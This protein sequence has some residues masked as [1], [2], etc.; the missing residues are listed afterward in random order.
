MATLASGVMQGDLPYALMGLGAAIAL[1]VECSGAV[2]L[3]FAIGL[4]LPITTSAPLILGGLLRSALERRERG[5]T[6]RATL[7]A[8]GL[9][10]GDALMGIGIAGLVVSGLAERL[11]LRTVG[12]AGSPLEIV[13]TVAPFAMLALALA[14]WARPTAG[15]PAA[16]D[17]H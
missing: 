2:T 7:L 1:A 17:G 3:A 14:R 6:E 16:P 4:Y 5:M 9:I 13:L 12:P 10:A 8:S 11:A 15:G